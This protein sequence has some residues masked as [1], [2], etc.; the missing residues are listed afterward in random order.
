ML[1]NS[2]RQGNYLRRYSIFVA[3]DDA[4]PIMGG[5]RRGKLSIIVIKISTAWWYFIIGVKSKG[6]IKFAFSPALDI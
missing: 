2:W 4:Y 6:I 1:E 3:W 5:G